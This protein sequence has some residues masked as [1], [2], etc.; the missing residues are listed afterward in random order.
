MGGAGVLIVARHV[1]GADMLEV[2]PRLLLGS[3]GDAL[4]VF[5]RVRSVVAQYR[6]THVLSLCNERPEWMDVLAAPEQNTGSN[7]EA[8]GVEEDEETSLTKGGCVRAFF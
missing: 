6:V 2:C 5:T 8:E 7:E 1:C 4:A 3:M